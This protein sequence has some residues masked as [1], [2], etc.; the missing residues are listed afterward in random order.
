MYT[1]SQK[2]SQD[3]NTLTNQRSSHFAKF[4]IVLEIKGVDPNHYH[5]LDFPP[6]VVDWDWNP[7]VVLYDVSKAV[8]TALYADGLCQNGSIC[9]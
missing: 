1:T 5:R 9:M 2:E 4:A 8:A 3:N 7:L 6:L